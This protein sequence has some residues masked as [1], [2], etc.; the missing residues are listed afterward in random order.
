MKSAYFIKI[1]VTENN[2]RYYKMYQNSPTSFLV[3]IGRI[4]VRPVTRPYPI[5]AWDAMYQ[6]KLAEGY[7]ERTQYAKAVV[8]GSQYREIEDAQVRELIRFLQQE[9]SMAVKR[10]YTV[11]FEEITPQMIR[12][13]EDLLSGYGEDP[14][15]NNAILCRLFAIVPRK[16]DRVQDYLLPE[17]ASKEEIFSVLRREQELLDV[18][19]TK[20]CIDRNT[21]LNPSKP[22]WNHGILPLPV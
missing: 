12:D 8:S 4:G 5:R 6:R 14:C 21:S 7:V 17:D 1:D 19:R 11:S 2:N 18:L 20:I 3:E 10:N 9:R 15:K 22:C 13:A 16:M